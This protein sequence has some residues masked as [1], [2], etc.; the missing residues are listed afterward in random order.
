MPKRGTVSI[1]LTQREAREVVE[2]LRTAKL[3]EHCTVTIFTNEVD[4]LLRRFAIEDRLDNAA[5]R[6]R[7]SQQFKIELTREHARLLIRWVSRPTPSWPGGPV[8]DSIDRRA[9]IAVQRVAK[10]CMAALRKRRGNPKKRRLTRGQVQ[11]RIEK[12]YGTRWTRS[13]A[14]RAR[15]YDLWDKESKGKKT[16]LG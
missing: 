2:W 16:L 3:S 11:S 5:I 7:S 12:G 8:V 9:P 14:K 10:R 1:E 4:E 15:D 6:K 13:L